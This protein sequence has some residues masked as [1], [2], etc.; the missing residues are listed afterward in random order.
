MWELAIIDF[1]AQLG[2]EMVCPLEFNSFSPKWYA[3]AMPPPSAPAIAIG[4][5]PAAEIQR[6]LSLKSFQTLLSK[7]IPK[8]LT[9]IQFHCNLW[10]A[11]YKKGISDDQVKSNVKLFRTCINLLSACEICLLVMFDSFSNFKK[12]PQ[13]NYCLPNLIQ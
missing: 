12:T 2:V 10:I 13:K 11:Q 6:N 1:Y 5:I 3:P 9:I 8:Q 4:R 7:V